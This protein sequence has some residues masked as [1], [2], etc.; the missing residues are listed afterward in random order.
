MPLRRS[1]N[2]SFDPLL[3]PFVPGRWGVVLWILVLY[4]LYSDVYFYFAGVCN[5]LYWIYCITSFLR[6]YCLFVITYLFT[7][8][9]AMFSGVIS[10]VW[11]QCRLRWYCRCLCNVCLSPGCV[12]RMS[13]IL[14]SQNQSLNWG[15][16]AIVILLVQCLGQLLRLS[17]IVLICFS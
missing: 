2:K 8:L 14:C 3:L 6:L 16:W 13:W 10:L 7:D 1:I 9:A 17:R 15:P 4:L 12:V 11:L 5:R